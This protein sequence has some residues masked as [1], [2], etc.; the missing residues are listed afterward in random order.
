MDIQ[1]TLNR[2][3]HIIM[4]EG[5][6]RRWNFWNISALGIM[7]GLGL[8]FG[9]LWFMLSR[10]IPIP[11]DT[12]MLAVISPKVGKQI[13]P[14]EFR[15]KIPVLCQDALSSDSDWPIIC[16]ITVSG[17]SFAISPRWLRSNS[18]TT[19][20]AG[21]IQRSGEVAGETKTFRYSSALY[22]RGLAKQ[23]TVLAESSAIEN[24]LGL[25]MTSTSTSVLFRWNGHGFDSDL[26]ISPQTTPLPAGD[27]AFSLDRAA[28]DTLPGDL[29]LDAVN[30][31][32]KNQWKPL[33]PIERY[34]VWLDEDRQIEGRFIGFSD[35]LNQEL[36][37]RILGMM[38]VTE[39]QALTLPDGTVS[40]ERLLPTAS[41]STNLF[42]RRQNDHGQWI[43]LSERFI[44]VSNASTTLDQTNVASCGTSYPWL[45]LSKNTVANLLGVTIPALQAY[46]NNHRLS[47]CFEQ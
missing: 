14:P 13:L 10:P 30:L 35:P 43:D 40:Y 27:I 31:P 8:F 47:I 28:W 12:A 16:G 34:A 42:G 45:R 17:Q 9:G 5:H 6:G 26:K 41:T 18:A 46:S 32:D 24:W 22:W 20:T 23:P 39:R 29:F 7:I 2:E 1:I 19:F 3:S 11:V 36:A 44:L 37:A 38:G 15:E 33:P 21:L 4:A 25:E